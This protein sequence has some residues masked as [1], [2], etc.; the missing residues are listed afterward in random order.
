MDTQPNSPYHKKY[1]IFIPSLLVVQESAVGGG[2]LGISIGALGNGT[3][4][5]P[6]PSLLA[7][8]CKLLPLESSASGALG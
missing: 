8:D 3:T 6:W 2:A 1:H 7:L 5:A 4:A